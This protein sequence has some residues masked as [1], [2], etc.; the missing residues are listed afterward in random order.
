M[1]K[2]GSTSA[3]DPAGEWEPELRDLARRRRISA[4]M[5]GTAAIEKMHSQG[6]LTARERIDKLFDK[7]TFREV[8]ALTGKASY[9]ESGELKDFVPSNAVTGIGQIDGRRVS[10]SADDFTIRGGSSESTN[11]EKWIQAE[12]Y[13]YE[14][15]MPLVR[16]VDTAGGSVRLLEQQQS[17]KIPGYVNWPM[18]A[19]L[20][21]VPVVGVALG[22]C[23]GLGALKVLASHF[24]VMVR[25]TSQIFA[26]GP[27]V[28]KRAFGVDVHKNDLGGYMVHS[29]K[30][31]IVDNE[32]A[33]D[34]DAIQQARRFLSYLPINASEMP[35]RLTSS[36]PVDRAEDWLKDAIPRDSRRAY[37]VR[38]ILD[39]VLDKGSTFE[40][41]RYHGGSVVTALARMD[42]IAVGVMASNP[43]VAAGSMTLTAANKIERLIELCD[44]FHLPILN[45]VDQPGVMVGVEA[46]QQGTL[47]SVMRVIR[48]MD[49]T[50]VP[51]MSVIMRRAFGLAGGMQGR[52]Q[53]GDGRSLNHRV[54]W[55]SARWGS[56]PIEG[57]VAAAYKRDI[58][59]AADPVERQAELEAYY[60]RL[61]S[62][63]RTAERFGIADI[64]D[65]R[66]TRPLLCE[67]VHDAYNL[68]RSS[69]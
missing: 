55:P 67:W 63:F 33:D 10:V 28:V 18:A 15:R 60:G 17:T 9:D 51:W 27:P 52:K 45:F 32:A 29:R 69:V 37:D 31:G 5:G 43:A 14:A 57:G 23:A 41:G 22:A 35:A 48:M 47:L 58:E 20:N 1:T 11:S 2:E 30:S 40:I 16:L 46:E 62:P 34:V 7:G 25:D 3:F 26:A 68:L 53:S 8:G 49:R 65:P 6:K 66:G 24:S 36:D 42:G 61:S 4:A 19:L 21:R 39:A 13:A 54:A 44:T 50:T 64:I 59:A 38:K 12:R 56:I